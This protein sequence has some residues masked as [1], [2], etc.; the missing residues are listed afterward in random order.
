MSVRYIGSKARIVN[1][2]M[3]LVGPSDGRGVFIDAFC[4]TG[5]VAEAAAEHGWPVR[6]NDHL[7]C[8]VTIA[9]ARLIGAEH[10]TFEAFGGYPQAIERLNA[11]PTTPG[12]VWREYSAAAATHAAITQLPRLYF[13][14]ENAARID[15]MRQ[16]IASWSR[17]GNLSA[18]EE[19]L[20][21]GDLLIAANAVANIAGTF[22]CFLRQLAPNARRPIKVA[23]RRLFKGNSSVETS[24]VDV[25]DVAAHREDV[26]Y[27]DPP[28]TKRQYAAYY[29]LLETI[30]CG[31]EPVVEGVTGLRP[32]KAK[33][34]PFCY[35][36]RALAAIDK[37]IAGT[38]SKRVLLS[39]S[40]E[41]HVPLSDLLESLS[42][43]GAVTMHRLGEI[44]RYRPNQT[45]ADRGES[46][47]E[48][49]IEVVK[50]ATSRELEEDVA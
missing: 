16:T 5:S 43:T 32:W 39:Y 2:I 37:L 18:D 1:E 15:S 48:V 17:A 33:A 20:L 38:P 47:S 50:P 34:S 6:I 21:L 41:G 46:V 26:I 11:T 36:A 4:G 8:A 49:V 13:T 12:F 40:S 27:Y 10:A 31:D 28:Y 45:A 14:E 19:T 44:G 35:K 7:K 29:H 9:G 42:S 3:E 22:G 24:N 30:A 23:P 25:Y